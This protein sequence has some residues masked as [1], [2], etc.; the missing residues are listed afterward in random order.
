[1]ALSR[2]RR[3]PR[4]LDEKTLEELAIRYVERF[5]TTR[6]KLRSYLKRKV[7]E[8]GWEAANEPQI[9]SIAERFANQGYVDD[10]AYALA[11]SQ[12]LSARGYG[13]RRL[14]EKLRA[15]GVEEAD[16]EAARDHADNEA[17]E[18]ALKFAS[19]RRIGPFASVACRE[20][21]ERER[22]LAAM[23]RAGHSFSL[24][25]EIV[26]LAPGTEIEIREIA[27]RAR[28]TAN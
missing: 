25:R 16:S 2:E 9:E 26:D 21:R 18:S 13:K 15:A 10:A 19:R 22:A 17:I 3:R 27:E 28:L 5:A 6:A 11:K 23:V 14:I 8:R 7:R 24:A 20:P 1:M 4:P 12:S